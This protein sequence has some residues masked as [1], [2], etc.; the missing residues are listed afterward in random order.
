M[1]QAHQRLTV[2]A[3]TFGLWVQVWLMSV[4]T[5]LF[6]ACSSS[7]DSASGAGYSAPFPGSTSP[8]SNPSSENGSVLVPGGTN[9]NLGGSQDFGFFRGQL[10][11]GIVPTSE[12]LDA[13]GFFAEHHHELPPPSCGNRICL[14]PMLA[15]MGN[16]SDGANCTMLHLGLNSPIVADPAHRPPLSLAVVVDVSGSMSGAKLE[17]VKQGLSVLIDKMR[18]GDRLA[19]I[20]YSDSATTI[21]PMAPVELQR[22]TLREQIAK[23]YATG[24]TNIALGLETGYHA[25]LQNLDGARQNRVILLSDGVPTVGVTD[26]PSIIQMS[27]GYNGEGIGITTIGLGADFNVDL[28]RNLALQADG[29]FYFLENTGAVKE[30]FEEE[31]DFFS[32]PVAFDL[33]LRLKTGASYKFGRAVGSPFF[34]TT[35]EGGS[36]DVPSVFVAHRTSHADVTNENGRR[37]GGS[38]LLVELLPSIEGP[39]TSEVEV[40]QVEISFRE[41]GTNRVVTDV[42]SIKYPYSPTYLASTGYFQAQNTPAIQK[43]FVMLNILAGMERAILAFHSGRANENTI[44]EL[45]Q[46]MAAVVDYNEEVA[47]VDIQLDYELLVQLRA[48]LLRAGVRAPAPS[49]FPNAWPAD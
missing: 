30:V 49:P 43:S 45:D 22:V 33:S 3:R 23:L 29:N 26:T 13:A 28:M 17:Y 14:Q 47:D 37:G 19:L 32:V 16:L 44:R 18:D 4:A 9:I 21:A 40:A 20:T 15:V 46:L 27:R 35:P 5:L 38:A 25:V 2:F 39:A 34:K 10:N 41:P 36:L 1:S 6:S 12:A 31:V 11:S 24:G 8:V 7:V 42:V 48:N